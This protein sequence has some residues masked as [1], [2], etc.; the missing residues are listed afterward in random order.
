MTTHGAAQGRTV[1]GQLAEFFVDVKADALPPLAYERA[2]M[3]IA[4]T[5]S[6]AAMGYGIDSSRIFRELAYDRG[7]TPE[8]SIWFDTGAQLPLVDA[9]RANAV[10]S[11]AAA[12]DDSDLRQIAH[13]GTTVTS[14]GLAVGERTGAAGRDILAAMI[15]GYEAAG[16]ICET[17]RSSEMGIH[18]GVITIFGATV[19]AGRLLHLDHAQMTNAI[20]LAATS[21]GGI[22][23]ASNTSLA[24]EYDAGL[25]VTLGMTAAMAGQ[26]GFPAETR[27]LEMPR[28]F[29]E[30][31]GAVDP[32]S[33]TRDLGGSWDIATNMAI[34]L[35]PGGHPSHGAVYA[36]EEAARMAKARPEDIEAIIVRAPAYR[37]LLHPTDLV[38]VA[39]SV[40]FMVAC[41]VA[42]GAYTWAHA[43]E[44][45]IHDPVIWALQEKVRG[46]DAPPNAAAL[47]VNRG[48]CVTIRTKSGQEFTATVEA[49][50]GSAPTGIDWADVDEK[51]RTLAPLAVRS[52]HLEAS[53]QAI[54]DFESAPD[55]KA[56]IELLR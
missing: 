23:A 5:V 3:A 10:A 54:H 41:A 31:Y 11:D 46:G 52:E 44:E 48:G 18:T 45:K 15:V 55:G 9:A 4:S 17:V 40:T 36:A 19:T 56:L 26:K 13:T 21:I 42:D 7:G 35:I 25:A 1:A 12:S 49:P 27:I 43:S 14:T 2:R 20:A 28:G 6:S 32:D 33:V 22:S 29:F 50:R 8:A 47:A 51:Y 38:G 16:R 30:I 39:H 24:R 37:P 34:K 53:L